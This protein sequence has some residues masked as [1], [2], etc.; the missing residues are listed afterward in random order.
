MFSKMTFVVLLS[1]AISVLKGQENYRWF[2]PLAVK[3]VQGRVNNHKI[4]GLAASRRFE[5]TRTGPSM[6]IG[7]ECCR[8]LY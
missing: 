2:S 8:P 1:L 5:R 6:V 3:Q 7:A 4:S